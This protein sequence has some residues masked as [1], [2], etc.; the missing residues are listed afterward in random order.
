MNY[1]PPPYSPAHQITYHEMMGQLGD[2]IMMRF[3]II[4]V[5]MLIYTY[6]CRCGMRREFNSPYN[7]HLKQLMV[8]IFKEEAEDTINK[9]NGFLDGLVSSIAFVS[10][11]TWILY[12]AG[13][14]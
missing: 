14:N 3:L 10:I 12:T 1:T 4:G 7:S 6:W 13:V 2:Q 9:L 11:G 5:V 8:K